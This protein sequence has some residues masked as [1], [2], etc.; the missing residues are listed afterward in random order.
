MSNEQWTTV[1]VGATVPVIVVAPFLWLIDEHLRADE[2]RLERETARLQLL[3]DTRDQALRD[4]I[5]QGFERI[6]QR[7]K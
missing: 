5:T 4:E 1:V 6:E 2:A 7:L 3:L